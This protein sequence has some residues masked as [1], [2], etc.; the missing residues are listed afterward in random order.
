ME[1]IL[2]QEQKVETTGVGTPK[3]E[4]PEEARA[5]WT[6][7]STERNKRLALDPDC[8]VIISVGG[9]VGFG[10][11][12]ALIGLDRAVNN[13]KRNAGFRIPIDEVVE[14]LKKVERFVDGIWEDVKTFIPR[15]H[16]FQPQKW[17]EINDTKE[18]R[19]SLAGRRS[20]RSIVP[21]DESVARIVMAVKL[22]N[23]K[24]L[25]FQANSNFDELSKLVEKYKA[26]DEGISNFVKEEL[27][28]TEQGAERPVASDADTSKKEKAERGKKSPKP[29][30]EAK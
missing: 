17:R 16:S 7:E 5:R 14:K 30:D 1:G 12:K 24:I 15:L 20:A 28:N 10:L 26:L 27:S 9:R 2:T 4:T 8:I 6:A 11:T 22:L 29:Q 21:R 3:V 19:L 23:S 25:E 13:L 18:E